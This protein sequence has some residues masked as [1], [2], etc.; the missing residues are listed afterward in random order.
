MIRQPKH[1]EIYQLVFELLSQDHLRAVAID[2]RVPHPTFNRHR[3]E[4]AKEIL[5]EPLGIH[6][7]DLAVNNRRQ[8]SFQLF[9]QSIFQK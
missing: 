6:V 3:A 8:F 4:F 7:Y 1:Y 2:P 9:W 5:Q